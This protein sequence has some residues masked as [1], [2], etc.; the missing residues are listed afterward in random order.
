MLTVKHSP[1]SRLNATLTKSLPSFFQPLSFLGPFFCSPYWDNFII[2]AQIQWPK[3]LF[4]PTTADPTP[5]TFR[6]IS[7]TMAP[8]E[9]WVRKTFWRGRMNKV[10][11]YFC[12]RRRF[13]LRIHIRHNLQL[14]SS[15]AAAVDIAP[16]H[17]S[18]ILQ[19]NC[20]RNTWHRPP[21]PYPEPEIKTPR[22]PNKILHIQM[23]N[24]QPYNAATALTEIYNSLVTKCLP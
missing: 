2:W 6:N 15:S 1:W 10:I 4:T 5:L 23:Y 20:E 8:C 16:Q 11:K 3:N 14:S 9:A 17:S 24:K 12:C 7:S 21:N 18:S 13:S 19:K 22:S